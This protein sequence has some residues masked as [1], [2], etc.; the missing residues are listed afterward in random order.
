MEIDT[1]EGKSLRSL[2]RALN[3]LVKQLCEKIDGL[4][5]ELQANVNDVKNVAQEALHIAKDSKLA[6][7]SV[8]QQP[9]AAIPI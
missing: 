8:Q 9:Y 4:I 7:D 5:T 6:F 1:D 2:I 3:N